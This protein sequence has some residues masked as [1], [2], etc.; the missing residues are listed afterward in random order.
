MTCA[1]RSSRPS[2][3]TWNRPQGPAPMMTQSVCTTLITGRSGSAWGP[4]FTLPASAAESCVRA[5][6]YTGG[7]M[8][9][10]GIRE[11]TAA[12]G[13]PA[14]RR[15]LAVDDDPLTTKLLRL[16]FES[17]RFDV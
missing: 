3:K 4:D 10:V 8:S 5:S 15:L 1:L 2:S 14:R 13:A 7:T 17:Q 12:T 16:V 9:T 11:E 6:R